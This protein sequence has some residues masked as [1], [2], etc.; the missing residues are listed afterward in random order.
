MA[1][2]TKRRRSVAKKQAGAASPGRPFPRAALR[3][4]PSGGAIVNTGSITGLQG[5]KELLDYS[6]T[7]GAIHAFTKALAQQLVERKICVNC[8]APGPI[9]TPLNVVDKPAPKAA[10]HGSDVRCSGPASR[11]K[12]HRRTCSSRRT[13]TAATSPA[14][15]SPSSAARRQPP[16]DTLRRKHEYRTG[17]SCRARADGSAVCTSQ[18]TSRGPQGPKRMAPSPERWA[19]HQ[20]Q[21]LTLQE[22][23]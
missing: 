18:A 22:E 15:C 9:W 5:S 10:K 21:G 16:R 14:K 20:A 6:A 4:L 17:L 7:K 8:V 13:Q 3:H 19:P 1:P 2:Q 23:L 11:R 12:S